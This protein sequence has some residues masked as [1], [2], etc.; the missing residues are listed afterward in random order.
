MGLPRRPHLITFFA[1]KGESETL[2]K[3]PLALPL[4]CVL[5]HSFPE[6]WPAYKKMHSFSSP[7]PHGGFIG[8]AICLCL[9]GLCSLL[10][11]LGWG[12]TVP[13]T[14]LHTDFLPSGSWRKLFGREVTCHFSYSPKTFSYFHLFLHVVFLQKMDLIRINFTR[15]YQSGCWERGHAVSP[16]FMNQDTHNYSSYCITYHMELI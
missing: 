13:Q 12:V 11:T 10:T 8:D 7:P 9:Q 3:E 15:A 6:Q 16:Y 14:G 1:G 5:L 4:P 2:G